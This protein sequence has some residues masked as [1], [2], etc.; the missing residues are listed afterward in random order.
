VSADLGVVALGRMP[1]GEA[2]ALQRDLAARRIAGTLPTDLLLLVEHPP[3][4]TLGRGFHPEHLSTPLA[5]LEARGIEVHDIERGGD[6][7]FHGPGQ[8]VGYPIF[9]L[10]GHRQDLH[11][12]LRQMEEALISAIGDFG[13]AGERVAGYTGVWTAGRKI[14]SIGIHVRQ[15]V[16]WH[17]FALNVTTD[18]SYFDL[19]VPCGIP[20]VQ[21]TSIQRELRERAPRDLWNRTTDNVI[22]AFAEVFG[23]R[24][25]MQEVG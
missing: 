6:V 13:I 15:W 5:A 9:D 19:I 22:G 23:M 10:R 18:L 8:L 25:Q 16:T 21:M 7:T 2:L 4:I 11:W 3:V 24:P 1:Y 12:F 20:N 14:A 17:G